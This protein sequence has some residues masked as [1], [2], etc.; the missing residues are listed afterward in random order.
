MS[1]GNPLTAAW[2]GW[3]LRHSMRLGASD[4]EAEVE[5]D[6]DMK[7]VSTMDPECV[8]RTDT[9]VHSAPPSV[10]LLSTRMAVSFDRNAAANPPWRQG[11]HSTGPVCRVAE[12]GRSTHFHISYGSGLRRNK[13]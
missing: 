12:L 7:G 8:L 11:L 13:L 9:V 10:A 1:G 4:A 2:V 5:V 3:R 6:F